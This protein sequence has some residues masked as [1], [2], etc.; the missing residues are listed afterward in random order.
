MSSPCKL[1]H[2]PIL[3]SCPQFVI[4]C[5]SPCSL[6]YHRQPEVRVC[7][8]IDLSIFNGPT[9]PGAGTIVSRFRWARDAVRARCRS[10]LLKARVHNLESA[11]REIP[12]DA[13]VSISPLVLHEKSTETSRWPLPG[14]KKVKKSPKYK[15]N[16]LLRVMTAGTQVLLMIV[17]IQT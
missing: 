14:K 11:L 1:F 16:M 2:C 7:L 4:L 15:M 8:C 13:D 5:C 3:S 12:G 9:F 6:N 10:M 17:Q